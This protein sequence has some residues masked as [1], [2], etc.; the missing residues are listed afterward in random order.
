MAWLVRD[1]EVLA[2]A[3]IADDRGAPGGGACSAATAF[4]GALVL[5]PCRQ[6]HTVGHAVPDRRRV[7]RRATAWCCAR[8]TLRARGGSRRSVRRA[9]FVDR[10]R[11]RAR[12]TGGGSRVGDRVELRGVTAPRTAAD[13][14]VLVATPIGNL[15]DLSPRAVEALRDADVIAAEDTRRTRALLTHAGR[16]GGRAAARGARAQ[17]AG[18]R[19]VDRRRGARRA[20]RVAYVTDAGMPGISDPGER[21]VRACLD[22][23]LAVEVVPGPERGAHRARALGLPDR[24]VRVRGLPAPQGPRRG[25]SG[26]PRSCRETAHRRAVRG[27]QAGRATLADLLAR[28]RPAARGRRRPRAHQAARGGVARHARRGRRPRRELTEPRGEHVL[29]LAAR[30]R[31]RPRPS[32]DEID[33]HVRGGARP[34]A[35]RPATPPPRVAARPRRAPPPR[36]RRG[37][38]PQ[39]R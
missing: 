17:R 21:L 38:A 31:R 9:A 4:D 19:G 12:S 30:A 25:A 2:A 36:L 11:G 14:L 33:A 27:A 32:D 13:A 18:E 24:P 10:G 1:G 20:T 22:A 3:E 34:R 15:G 6:V 35:C 7:L 5:R 28:V 37:H 23:G 26:S 29:V 39:A 8:A 16:P